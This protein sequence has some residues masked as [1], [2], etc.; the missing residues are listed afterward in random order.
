MFYKIVLLNTMGK[1]ISHL[2]RPSLLTT[3][4]LTSEKG[5]V[6]NEHHSYI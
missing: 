3:P 2:P 6:T 4:S 1:R 5:A